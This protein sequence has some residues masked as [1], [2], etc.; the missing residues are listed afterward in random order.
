MLR[1]N[2]KQ[3][4][5]FGLIYALSK[6]Y[7]S[8]LLMIF[9]FLNQTDVYVRCQK[10][11]DWRPFT[12]CPPLLDTSEYDQIKQSIMVTLKCHWGQLIY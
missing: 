4:I 6:L 8:V 12:N 9:T 5:M 1:Y 7:R 11:V 10:I 3:W 2:D